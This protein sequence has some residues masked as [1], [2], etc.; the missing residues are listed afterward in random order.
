MAD[1]HDTHGSLDV[2]F[3]LPAN[4]QAL[5][6]DLGL[7][8]NKVDRS[9]EPA[10]QATAIDREG[11]DAAMAIQK[12]ARWNGSFDVSG[13]VIDEAKFLTVDE[14]TVAGVKYI[15]VNAKV[16]DAVREFVEGSC[17]MISRAKI[18]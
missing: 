3:G 1:T 16:G 15:V 8:V 13:K 12:R 14:V 6:N 5:S 9:Y 10:F 11:E 4:Q 2:T 7:E 18:T 17:T